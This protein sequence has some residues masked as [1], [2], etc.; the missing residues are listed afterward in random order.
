MDSADSFLATDFA[1]FAVFFFTFLTGIFWITDH[2][3]GAETS[4]TE[5]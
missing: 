5:R 1:N 2:K 3:F 4:R